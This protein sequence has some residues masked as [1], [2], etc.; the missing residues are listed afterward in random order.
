M[1]SFSGVT[2]V[3]LCFVFRLYAFVEA[4][5]LR[6]I[7]L[8]CAG[9]PI[10]TRVS[11]FFPFIYL[12]MSPFPSIFVFFVPFPLSLCMESTSYV[13]SFRMVFCYLVTT[14]WIFDIS[15]CENLINQSINHYFSFHLQPMGLKVAILPVDT[16]DLPI[17][18]RDASL[19]LLQLVNQW[20]HFT[21]S[22]SHAFRYGRNNTNSGDKNRTHDFRTSRWAGYLLDHS[23]DEYTVPTPTSLTFRLT[24]YGTMVL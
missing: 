9:P 23:G 1:T 2:F 16:K 22:R 6:S 20:L 4:A 19:A 24:N 14:G 12:E 7:V 18:P 5:A 15:L 11:F 13:L 3:L 17:S 8:R 10:A 21:Y